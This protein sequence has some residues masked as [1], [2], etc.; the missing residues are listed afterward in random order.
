MTR[1]ASILP[2]ENDMLQITV[3]AEDAHALAV[4][5]KP[6]PVCRVPTSE[7]TKAIRERFSGGLMKALTMRDTANFR[8]RG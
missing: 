7:A 4:A 8:V 3:P 2:I 6:C 5:L 1:S